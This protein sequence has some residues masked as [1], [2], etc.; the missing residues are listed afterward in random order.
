M[1]AHADHK[2]LA[3]WIDEEIDLAADAEE[4]IATELLKTWNV[5]WLHDG[6]PTTAPVSHRR[7]VNVLDDADIGDYDQF[8]AEILAD[9]LTSELAFS[10][11][12]AANYAQ[13]ALD[14]VEAE[15]GHLEPDLARLYALLAL[16]TGAET[17][18]QDVHDAWSIWRTATNPHHSS[19]VPFRELAPETQELD[20]PFRDAIVRAAATL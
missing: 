5:T 12:V 8:G 13:A 19:L 16:V 15:A 3:A 6:Q 2:E 10:R 14:T 7:L 17:T 4:Q 9:A 1:P 18:A 11:Q 20:Q